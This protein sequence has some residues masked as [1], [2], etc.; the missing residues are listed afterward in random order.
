MRIS[1]HKRLF[2]GLFAVLTA[3]SLVGCHAD[4]ADS[5]STAEKPAEKQPTLFDTYVSN[6]VI[7]TGCN[8]IIKN[9]E[10]VTYRAWFPVEAAGS[11]DYRFYFSNTV[12]STWGDGSDSYVGMPGGSYTIESAKVYDGGTEF[13]ANVTPSV[14]VP[15]TFSNG[16]TTKEVQPDET[17]WSDTVNITIPE[18]HYLLWEWTIS[19]SNIP[20]IAMSNL[21][22]SYADH[23][24]GKG[25][26]YTNEI[27]VPQLVGCDR[28]VSARIVTLGDSVTQ[29]CQTTEFAQQFWAAQ[30][31]DQ[32]GAEDYSLWNLGIGYARASD[33]A[34]D[35]DWLNRAIAGA[36]VITVAFGTN[37][38]ISGPYGGNGHATADEMENDVRKITQKCTDSGIKTILWNSP[39]FDLTPELEEIRTAY[40]QKV[41]GIAD[42]CGAS[43]FDVAALLA[44]PSDAAKTVYGQH[45]N[46]EGGTVIAD[47][48]VK[49]VRE[50]EKTSE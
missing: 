16:S 1:K 23:G 7:S 25:F 30:L 31:L 26:L 15:V 40:N 34:K 22:Y 43:Y 24:D 47:A 13:D 12:D 10:S 18:D 32:L 8:T 35:E 38:I 20:A 50:I 19:G 11:F 46:D 37:D 28:E 45:P 44:D 27:P 9:A 6:T 36:D 33:C 42:D 49:V 17:F 2:G 4:S 5:G 3:A 39:P 21:A 14:S 29:G 48:L 41:E